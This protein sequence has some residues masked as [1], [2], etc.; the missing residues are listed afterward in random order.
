MAQQ[1]R[2]SR[3]QFL[4]RGA[5]AAAASFAAPY[6]VPAGVLAAG[7]RTGANDRIQIGCIGAGRRAREVMHLPPDARIVAVSDVYLKRMDEFAKGSPLKKYQDYRKLLESKDVDA[8][9][10]TTP[11]HWHA[12]NSIHACQAGKDV[13]CEKPMS[14]TVREGRAMVEAARQHKR[15]F[16][17]GSQQ[18]S[19][20][21]C[22]LGCELVRNGRIGKIQTVH[23][24]NYPSPWEP[25]FPEQP[26]PEGLN[27][28]MWLGQ[29]PVRPYHEEIYLPRVRGTE[30]GWISFRAYSGGEMT[31]WGSH[32]LDM[33]QWALGMDESGPVE[34][35]PEGSG[36]KC[37]VTFR[38]ESGVKVCL[39]G[40]GPHGG[41]LFIGEKGTILIDRQ[42][43]QSR[44]EEI[45]K[46]PLKASDI[47]LYKS[48]N[49]MR[50]WLECIRSRKIPVA[51]VEIGHRSAT[52]CHLGNIAR[53][54]GR[55]LRWDPVREAF[56]G[57]EEANRLLERPM[58]APWSL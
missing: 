37:P 36:L 46:E 1:K 56:A 17:T 55:K 39:D 41:G 18:R 42:K 26:V 34:V 53:W 20:E 44:P 50:N 16:Q 11:D 21:E 28:D 52:V 38:Y 35:W 32:G 23:V 25:N 30:A 19:M 8:V 33:I 7:G 22:R 4:K 57:D 12:Q 40:K 24:D 29:T 15:V 10:V 43:C 49:H 48:A 27:W 6:F 9:V 14:L 58:R 3:R 47:H 13:Y 45:A 5:Q 31:G 54:T 51:D 2:V